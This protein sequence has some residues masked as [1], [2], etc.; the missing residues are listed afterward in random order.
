MWHLHAIILQLSPKG[1][2]DAAA[3]S[4]LYCAASTATSRGRPL[5]ATFLSSSYSASPLQPS[6][7][8]AGARPAACSPLADAQTASAPGSVSY[9]SPCLTPLS[10]PSDFPSTAV[11]T[12]GSAAGSLVANPLLFGAPAAS[13]L[14]HVAPSVRCM[15]SPGVDGGSATKYQRAM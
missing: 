2:V 10:A 5:G 1:V 7:S 14:G 3:G 8:L 12:S 13:P 9:I 6:N 11:P 4:P 15:S